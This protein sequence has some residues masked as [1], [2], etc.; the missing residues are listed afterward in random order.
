MMNHPRFAFLLHAGMTARRRCCRWMSLITDTI[1][2]D[3]RDREFLHLCEARGGGRWTLSLAKVPQDMQ[4]D[5]TIRHLLGDFAR[6]AAREAGDR[7]KQHMATM[8]HLFH[9]WDRD[10]STAQ[11]GGLRMATKRDT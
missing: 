11:R 5:Q 10:T 1:R 4:T 2:Q 9:G 7:L 6:R 3:M 8:M